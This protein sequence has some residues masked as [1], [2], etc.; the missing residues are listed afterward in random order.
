MHKIETENV[1]QD[2]SNN[3]EMIHFSNY[4][5]ESKYNDDSNKLVIWKMKDETVGFALKDLSD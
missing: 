2:F 4:S 1:Y 5:T 3:K